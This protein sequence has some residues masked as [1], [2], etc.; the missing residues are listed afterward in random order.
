MNRKPK[1]KQPIYV[2]LG[3]LG[4]H[5]LLPDD[6]EWIISHMNPDG[7]VN[8]SRLEASAQYK[9]N[10]G[11]DLTIDFS[12]AHTIGAWEVLSPFFH[13]RA[14][15]STVWNDVFFDA[16]R[17]TALKY[18]EYGITYAYYLFEHCHT[19]KPE[20][21]RYSAW[22]EFDRFFYGSDAQPTR[23]EY[24]KRF[25]AATLDTG[26]LYAACNEPKSGQSEMLADVI[27]ELRQLDVPWERI[28]LPIDMYLKKKPPYLND[29]MKMR[30]ILSH[31]LSIDEEEMGTILKEQCISTIHQAHK[32]TKDFFGKDYRPGATRSIVLDFDGDN[33]NGKRPTGS[34]AYEYARWVIAERDEAFK[35]GKIH[36][37]VTRKKKDDPESIEGIVR[38]CREAGYTP[39]PDHINQYP[40]AVFPGP[41]GKTTP[42]PTGEAVEIDSLVARIRKGMEPV[43]TAKMHLDAAIKNLKDVIG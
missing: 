18:K 15:V 20:T 14:N 9:A 13:N 41:W 32:N 31:R 12:W 29:Y 42:P 27:Y 36:F 22:S 19:K 35:D 39:N 34:Q 33:N 37:H 4:G 23:N 8:A 25:V 7:T 43:L 16:Q 2:G 6:E 21:A 17:E 30:K 5:S 10:M 1:F 40:E 11:V 38:A 26:M 24:L 28:I 3:D